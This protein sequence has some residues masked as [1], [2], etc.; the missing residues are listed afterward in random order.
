MKAIDLTQEHLK[1]LELYTAFDRRDDLN[2]LRPVLQ[3]L[4]RTQIEQETE[5]FKQEKPL[6]MENIRAWVYEQQQPTKA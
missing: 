2:R 5:R 3:R 1:L 4:F 6:S